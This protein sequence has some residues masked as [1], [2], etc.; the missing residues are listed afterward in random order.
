MH[1]FGKELKDLMSWEEMQKVL[2]EGQFQREGAQ[3][4]LQGKM[5]MPQGGEVLMQREEAVKLLENQLA[6]RDPYSKAT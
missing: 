1:P 4:V 6:L 2:H 3:K 5:V